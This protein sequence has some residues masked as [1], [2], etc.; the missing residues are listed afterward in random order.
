MGAPAPTMEKAQAAAEGPQLVRPRMSATPRFFRSLSTAVGSCPGTPPG[1][2]CCPVPGTASRRVR[3][4]GRSGEGQ[5][6]LEGR[7]RD[8]CLGPV[9]FVGISSTWAHE[10]ALT[11]RSEGASPAHPLGRPAIREDRRHKLD[12]RLGSTRV[13]R[14]LRPVA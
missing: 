3:S 2:V 6:V 11:G 9:P 7:W 4:A 12:P 10:G 5:S 8:R 13:R 1:G 14:A